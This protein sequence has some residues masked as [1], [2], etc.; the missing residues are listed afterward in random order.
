MTINQLP[1]FVHLKEIES[2]PQTHIFLSLF[3][4]NLMVQIFDISNL[5]YFTETEFIVWNI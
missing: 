5:N 1:L 3:L 4:R 2:L